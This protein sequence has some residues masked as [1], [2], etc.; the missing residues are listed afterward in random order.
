MRIILCCLVVLV[1]RTVSLHAA[2]NDAIKKTVKEKVTEMNDA[3]VKEDFG[4]VADLTHPKVVAGMG[5]REKMISVLQSGTVEMK[6]QGYA[7]QSVKVDEPLDPVKGGDDLYVVAPFQL[8]IKAPG[9]KL[10]SKTFVIGV[11][12]DKAKTWVFVNG[13]GDPA[14]LRKVL[15]N[16]PPDLK[17]PEKQKPVF[18]KE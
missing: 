12:N 13:D 4:K 18:E 16:L 6:K 11:S 2:E 7:F 14:E 9:G 15:P 8:E 5:G 3:L 17:F 10:T 1:F